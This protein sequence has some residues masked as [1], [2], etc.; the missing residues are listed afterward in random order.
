[1]K[2][3]LFLLLCTL[4]TMIGV[5]AQTDVTSTYLTNANFE[6]EYSSYAEPQSGR[7]IYK[8]NGWDITYTNGDSND[9]TSLNSSCTRWD[10]DFKNY[11]QPTNGGNNV[12]WTRLR[13]GANTK[14]TLS[15]TASSLPAGTYCLSAEA[16]KTTSN[17]VATISVAGK[18]VTID[19][20]SD[21]ATYSVIFTLTETSNVTISYSFEGKATD[22]R[23]GVD[24]FKLVNITQGGSDIIAQ[25]WTS[26]IANA[27]FENGTEGS[28]TGY[29]SGW[30]NKPVGY[31]GQL[32]T[33][34]TDGSINS[35]N[36]KDGSKCY[37]LWS[38]TFTS[39]NI[40]QDV[41]LP[42]GKYVIS[43]ALRIDNM[44]NV[45]DQ[46]VYAK[47]GENTYKSGTIT[48][49]AATWNSVEGWN[50]LDKVFYV[51]EENTTVRL[52]VSSTGNG[53]STQ[54]W[55]Q[56]DNFTLTYKGAVQNTPYSIAQGTATAAI[57]GK[58]Y[59][60][61]VP[62]DGEYRFIS[63]VDNTV[64]YTQKGYYAPS[65]A[66][67]QAVTAGVK[68]VVDLTEG[69]LYVQV[70][71]NATLTVEPD[72]YAYSVG[73]ATVNVSSI[74]K[75]NSVTITWA[76]ASTNNPE[77]SFAKNGTPNITFNGNSVDIETTAK[78][79]SFTVP[80]GLAAN[81]EYTLAIPANAF[82]YAAGS[83]YNAA[84]NI[85]LKT[86]MLLDGIYYFKVENE[87]AAKGKYL[88]RGSTNG[89]HATVDAYGLPIQVTTNTSN[90]TTLKA[91]DSGKYYVHS[92]SWDCNANGGTSTGGLYTI[93]LSG[94]KY[95]IHNNSMD[96]DR[97]LKYNTGDV[98]NSVISVYDDGTGSNSGP[99]ID[100][101]VETHSEH[102]TVLSTYSAKNYSNI[103]TAAG[104]DGVTPET[105]LTYLS[106]NYAAKDKTSSVETAKFEG[107][108]GSWTWTGVRNQ[109]NQPAYVTNAA[110]A[111]QA[112]G[113]WSQTITELPSGIYKVTVN[114][115][116]RDGGY[117]LCNTLA[118]EGYQIVTSYF[119][120]NTE[121]VQ[122]KSWYSDK[123]GTNNPNGTGEAATAFNNDKYKNEIYTYVSDEADGKGSL[124]L[125]L[126]KP[127]FISDNWVLFNNVTLTYYDASIT[128][129]EATA[130]INEAETEMEKPM[131]PSLYQ[132]LFTAKATFDGAR[133]MANYNSLRTA[134]DN[135]ATSI[136]SYA[137]MNS[138]YLSPIADLLSSSNIIDLTSSA[139]TEYVAYKNKYDNYKNSLTEDIDNAEANALTLYQSNGTRY[140]N[141][142]NI[143]MVT[144]WSINGN[145]ALT[146]GSGFYANT[147][148]GENAGTAPAADFSRPF[149]EMWVS[150]GSISA[151]TLTRTITGLTAHAI[152][153]V[154]ANVRVQY[155]SK[156]DNS[157]TMKAG[158][159]EAVDVTSGKKISSTDRYIDSYT[160]W[161][162]A[163]NEGNLIITFAVA[164]NSGISWLA[165]RDINYEVAPASVSATIG[166]NGYT[167]FASPYPLDLTEVNLLEGVKAYKASIID[168]TT[169]SFTKLNQVVPANTGILLKGT[170][171]DV[172]I[173]VGINPETV[174]E[175][176]LTA[177][178]G[179]LM[180]QDNDNYYFALKKNSNP[181]TF[182]KFLP[183]S[184]TIPTNKAYLKVD[185]GNFD[186]SEPEARLTIQIDGE[187][188]INAIEA[189]EANDGALKDGKYLIDG[190]IVIVKNGVKYDANG[191]KLN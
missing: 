155:T 83:T 154:T 184:I 52:G 108:A 75:G 71:N 135:T 28:F 5:Q 131:K 177:G 176:V 127:G 67:S 123:E 174:E 76:S 99:I 6:G 166:T 145:N 103:I 45:T 168:K 43:A 84:Q 100:W 163:D 158:S 119:K 152:Y 64:Y 56:L 132:A 188:A 114:A 160:A 35:T 73:D 48:S 126:A 101:S 25:N 17:G 44:D 96:N 72:V 118:G 4:L 179:V 32:E 106:T 161:G 20:R 11:R 57:S 51:T 78:G 147:W 29:S 115:F 186:S 9:M 1:M 105:F 37:N 15:Q 136:A 91:Y 133:N 159:G 143:L 125:T 98:N 34:W 189:A 121:Q 175:N 190:K 165:F 180:T 40:Y 69:T 49:V 183:E 81:T 42:R 66:E 109:N 7:N 181:M 70:A 50:T 120:A 173:P 86:P 102:M 30:A 191:K 124:T 18:S 80:G 88:S 107:A 2:K 59:A 39:S 171:G 31:S 187:T 117:N 8:P 138:N 110:E 36:P 47:I 62:A 139:Y 22:T 178:K 185:A 55:Y 150:S 153:K 97:F 65:D 128:D 85:T 95:R 53:S 13:W 23:I 134:I 3:K 46:G 79:F 93:T 21:W 38:N 74:Q 164:E 60:V 33:G 151:A 12:Y 140:T 170:A 146:N 130:I 111:W 26:M 149:Y 142:G 122:L 58:W 90:E 68:Q 156:V 24:N 141:K 116:E 129:E 92:G 10:D 104:L 27:S 41:I 89:E 19:G 182:A 148:S 137:T 82:G 94:G 157:I 54:G 172:I 16:Y 167:T 113:S 77:A 169:L 14:L 87:T 61:T 63:S 144:G 112:T 162:S